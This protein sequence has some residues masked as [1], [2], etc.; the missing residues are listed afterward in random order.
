MSRLALTCWTICALIIGTSLSG[1]APVV[2]VSLAQDACGIDQI[3]TCCQDPVDQD[4][5]PTPDGDDCCVDVLPPTAAETASPRAQSTRDADAA[6]SSRVPGAM[7]AIPPPQGNDFPR[8]GRYAL[9]CG[10]PRDAIA[11][12]RTSRLLL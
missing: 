5:P 8:H 1:G 9:R 10:P 11:V 7:L 12:V 2:C 6:L 3:E 4:C